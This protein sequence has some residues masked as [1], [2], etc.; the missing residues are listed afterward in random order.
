[1]YAPGPC[2]R[3]RQ[4]GQH[5]IGDVADARLQRQ[6]LGGIRPARISWSQEVQQ[7]FGDLRARL[8][9]GG[10]TGSAGPGR[11]SR[12]RRRSCPGRRAGRARRCAASAAISI[13]RRAVRRQ[14]GAVVDVVNALHGRADCSELTSMMT[15]SAMSSQVLLL[16][17]DEVGISQP[18]SVTPLDLDDRHV[19]LAV[20]TE[21]DVLGDVGQVDVDVFEHRRR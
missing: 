18:S 19:D 8:S 16:P 1:M 7:V 11:W 9:S 17:T 14:R 6:Q 3:R 15:L 10:R 2:N 21:P 4:P 12:P 5:G 20:E 13:D